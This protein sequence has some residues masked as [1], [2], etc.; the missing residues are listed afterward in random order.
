MAPDSDPPIV[1]LVRWTG[2][3]PDDDPNGVFK[4]EVVEYGRLDPLHTLEGMSA[5]LEVPIGALA[6]YVLA[7]WATAGSEGLLHLGSTAVERMWA[8]CQTAEAAD[9]DE[10]RLEAYESLRGMVSWLRIPLHEP[11]GY[12]E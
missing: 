9:T 4:D 2:P 5:S 8:A 11:A 3:W 10:A 7:K 1:E 12:D 6:R